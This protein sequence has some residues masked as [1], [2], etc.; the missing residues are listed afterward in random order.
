MLLCRMP[1]DRLAKGLA[2]VQGVINHKSPMPVLVNVLLSAETGLLNLNGTDLDHFIEVRMEA[3]VEGEGKTCLPAKKLYEIV[4]DM[5][6]GELVLEQ[7]EEHTVKI[8]GGEAEYKLRCFPAGDYPNTPRPSDIK[9]SKISGAA[10]K[11]MISKTIISVAQ[12]DPRVF[13]NGINF[14]RLEEKKFRMVSPDG[15]RLSLCDGNFD[16]E[17]E[18]ENK[19]ILP[20]KGLNEL[21]KL[22]EELDEK[23]ADIDFAVR[24]SSCWVARRDLF[25]MMRLIEGEFPD[26]SLVI[27]RNTRLTV[28]LGRTVFVDALRRI[29]LLSAERSFGVKIVFNKDGL[30]IASQNPDLGS[31]K[32]RV[33]ADYDLYELEEALVVGFNAKYFLDA[34]VNIDEET[35][36]LKL[37]DALAPCILR[38]EHSPNYLF[39]VM[40]MRL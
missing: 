37:S 10:L 32:E 13:L 24:G 15:H 38:P 1:K 12:D 28:T 29:S 3:T 36:Q 6:A 18:L 20:K 5:P 21:K 11:N 40:P 9:F 16:E 23:D 26:Y 33:P 27:P 22:L 25:F 35:V 7:F 2:R 39:V 34:L 8:S 4:K 31:A 14:E 19:V 17:P 30:E